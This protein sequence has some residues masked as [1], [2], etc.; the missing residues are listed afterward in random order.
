M[1]A[2]RSTGALPGRFGGPVRLPVVAN[3]GPNPAMAIVA[4][5]AGTGLPGLADLGVVV[6]AVVALGPLGLSPRGAPHPCTG[7]AA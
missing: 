3:V 2:G 5:A 7:P 4:L 1:A 6:A